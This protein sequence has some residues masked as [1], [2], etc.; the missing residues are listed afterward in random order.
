M[1][2]YERARYEDAKLAHKALMKFYPISLEN[3]EGELWKDI[4]EDDYKTDYQISTFGRIKSCKNG[5]SRILKPFIDKDGYLGIA[6]S[7]NAKVKK[8]KVHRLVAKAFIPNPENK[9]TV[10]HIDG[11]K[12]NNSISNLEWNSQSENNYHAIKTGLRKPQKNPKRKL[13]D[14]EVD[15][16]RKVHIPFHKEFGSTAL[17]NKFEIS[18]PCMNAILHHK[19]YKDIK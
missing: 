8:F 6:L 2:D 13:T 15:W 4:N 11:C 18:Q 5:H 3:L 14:M 12:M 10:N 16:C 9:E 1:T 19:T 7:K 17:A